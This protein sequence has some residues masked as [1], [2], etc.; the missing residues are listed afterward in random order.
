MRYKHLGKANVDVSAIGVGTWG[1][2]GISFGE[3]K[4]KDSIEAIR[5]EL[6]SGVNLIDTAPV[7]NNGQAEIIVGK[8]ISGIDRS[9]FMVSTKFDIGKTTLNYKRTGN[10]NARDAS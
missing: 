8:A 7:Y 1:I 10:E 6:D 9:K 5:T 2:G 3:V 4:E